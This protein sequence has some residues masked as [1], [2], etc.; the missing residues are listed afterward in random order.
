MH[1]HRFFKNII[2]AAQSASCVIAILCPL[3]A[4][5]AQPQTADPPPKNT[6]AETAHAQQTETTDLR[7]LELRA[8]NFFNSGNPDL[9]LKI[10]QQYEVQMVKEGWDALQPDL[11]YNQAVAANRAGLIGYAIAYLSQLNIINQSQD[12]QK[13][14]DELLLIVEHRTYQEFPNVQF[15]RG[16]PA[17]FNTWKQTHQL[18]TPQ[19]TLIFAIIWCLVIS[20]AAFAVINWKKHDRKFIKSFRIYT[21]VTFMLAAACIVFSIQRQIT[22]QCKFGILTDASDL[23]AGS[24]PLAPAFLDPSFNEGLSVQILNEN[25]GWLQIQR[26]DGRVAWTPQQ[27]VFILKGLGDF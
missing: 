19:T 13:L 24:S 1:N 2:R 3:P 8:K 21:I 14:I 26:V 18:S 4:A 25:N 7:Q 5:N 27:D 17:L 9:A 15:V 11:L 20:I 10:Y 16:Q 23:R 12:L 6:A 22:N